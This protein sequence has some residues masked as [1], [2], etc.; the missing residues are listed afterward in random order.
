MITSAMIF[1][2]GKGTRMMPLTANRPKP[3][4][5]VMGKPLLGHTLDK[6]RAAGI[7]HI[8]VNTHY[9]PEA[10]EQYV[11]GDIRLSH[12]TE[13]LETGGGV[14]KALREGLLPD[15][16]PF[17]TANSDILWTE[18]ATPA[19]TRLQQRWH[20]LGDTADILL[21]ITPKEKAWGH[22]S[23]NGDYAMDAEGR[24]T[25][26]SSPEAPHIFCGV[27]ILRPEL[28]AGRQNGERFTNR[29]IFDAAQAKGRLF[30]LLHTGG[31]YHFSTPDS[32]AQFAQMQADV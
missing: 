12:E 11:P 8:V 13:L 7:S 29:D 6:I 27:M 18:G 5:E 22:D 4:I 15:N 21:L 23:A 16:A 3:M 2:A 19:I 20:E 9:C 32:L 17:L 31:W 24:L 26:L 10:I 25:R 1:A 30:G 28:Y 14:T